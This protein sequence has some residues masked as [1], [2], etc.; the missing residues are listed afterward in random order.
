MAESRTASG[1]PGWVYTASAVVAVVLS[2]GMLVAGHIAWGLLGLLAAG[3]YGVA[4]R[5]WDERPTDL[6]APS[7]GSSRLRWPRYSEHPVLNRARWAAVGL[8]FIG[9]AVLLVVAA[10][11]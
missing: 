7:K 11:R 4:F 5:R 6:P 3:I 2:V 8:A 9:L 1:M 10:S